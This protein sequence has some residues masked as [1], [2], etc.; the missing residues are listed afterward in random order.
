MAAFED[1]WFLRQLQRFALG[2]AEQMSGRV[3][4]EEEEEEEVENLLGAP[5]EAFLAM[6]DR[7]LL[8][9][10]AG[11]GGFE[12]KR[13][14][15]VVVGF[16]TRALALDADDPAGAAALRAKAWR[17]LARTLEAAPDLLTPEVAALREALAQDRV[18]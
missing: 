6:A 11:A 15:A 2:V 18:H 8:T 1:D 10:F 16:S 9:M 14:L 7:S 3:V 4:R 12:G 5:I 17:L 13:A